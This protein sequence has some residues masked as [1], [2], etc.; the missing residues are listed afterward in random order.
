MDATPIIKAVKQAGDPEL[1]TMAAKLFHDLR[2]PLHIAQFRALLAKEAAD[3]G[4]IE[5]ANDHLAHVIGS[6]ELMDRQ[7]RDLRNQIHVGS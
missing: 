5:K 6:L 7:I 4:A 3:K 2:T 1:G